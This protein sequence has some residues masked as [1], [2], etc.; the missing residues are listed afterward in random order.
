MARD[1]A[2][3]ANIIIQRLPGP[4][5]GAGVGA[6]AR[7]RRRGDRRPGPGRMILRDVVMPPGFGGGW[8]GRMWGIGTKG[9]GEAVEWNCRRAAIGRMAAFGHPAGAER[10]M[11]RRTHGRTGPRPSGDA[12]AFIP[13]PSADARSV[14]RR[15][16][17]PSAD[18]AAIA[19]AR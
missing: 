4:R 3:V 2:G 17:I 16:A 19:P 10:G 9:H 18:G 7:S 15:P 12:P 13:L 11:A 5:P 14:R 8:A 6:A 1:K